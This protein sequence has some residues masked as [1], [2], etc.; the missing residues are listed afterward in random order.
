MK[1][2]SDSMFSFSALPKDVPTKEYILGMNQQS[3]FPSRMRSY[4]KWSEMGGG[5]NATDGNCNVL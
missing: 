5:H 2:V 3:L 4:R 1:T